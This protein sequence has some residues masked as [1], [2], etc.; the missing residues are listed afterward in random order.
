MINGLKGFFV[1][2]DIKWN[3]A[4]LH[5]SFS[6][7]RTFDQNFVF[8][9]IFSFLFQFLTIFLIEFSTK[10]PLNPNSKKFSLKTEIK[11]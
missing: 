8:I 4:I 2:F 7:I 1:K 9:E 3:F 10:S 6:F 5:K 11:L